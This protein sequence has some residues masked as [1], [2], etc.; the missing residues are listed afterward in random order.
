MSSSAYKVHEQG[1]DEE[2]NRVQVV[3]DVW[4]DIVVLHKL[5]Q[6]EFPLYTSTME[7]VGVSHQV[8]RFR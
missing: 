8:A 1:L 6:G 5:Q 3:G 2:L 7:Q 4:D